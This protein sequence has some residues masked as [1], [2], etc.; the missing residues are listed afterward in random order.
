[1][2]LTLDKE[3]NKFYIIYG[4]FHLG[5]M[6]VRLKIKG[7]NILSGEIKISG[8]KNSAVAL[9]PAA[10]L[11]K[12]KSKIYKVPKIRDIEYLLKILEVLSCK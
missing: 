10:L 2:N 6:N 7:G 1:M 12:T 3:N 5:G 8:S 4:T 11:C 9:L